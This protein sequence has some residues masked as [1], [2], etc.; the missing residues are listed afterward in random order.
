MR[1]RRYHRG[2]GA[3]LDRTKND[4]QKKP[5]GHGGGGGE[6]GQPATEV[7]VEEGEQDQHDGSCSEPD[8]ELEGE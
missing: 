6:P 4:R 1:S 7:D 2:K 8:D 3:V 5:G